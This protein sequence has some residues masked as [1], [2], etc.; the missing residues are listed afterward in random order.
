MRII[1]SLGGSIIVPEKVDID[2]LKE[3]RELMIYFVKKGHKF[4][5]Y[6]GGGALARNYQNSAS[7]IVKLSDEELDWLG[8]KATVLNA[9][10]IKTIFNEH[11]ES[12]IIINPTKEVKSGKPIIVAAG[13]KPG[14]STDYDAVLV[15]KTM[16][17][18]TVI[19]ITNVDYVY[20]KNPNK[21]NDARPIEELNWTDFRKLVGGK[22]DPGLNM[23][24]DP[25]AAKEAEKLGLKVYIVGKDS[26]N[27]GNV[28]SGNKFKG[29]VIR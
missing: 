14:W 25:I 18:D 20:D 16:E 21:H 9:N 3:F 13:W 23:P 22:W 1:I 8:I 26:K 12:E 10:L 27:L 2:F 6:C 17:I 15:A 11:A 19:N 28:L 24:F 4:V 7:K 29:T 5:I